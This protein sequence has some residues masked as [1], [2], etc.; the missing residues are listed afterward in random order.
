[1]AHLKHRCQMKVSN[2]AQ[3]ILTLWMKAPSNRDLIQ[4]GKR[5]VN[6]KD[7]KDKP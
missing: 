2:V 4:E 5:F 3:S 7:R 1:M 6:K